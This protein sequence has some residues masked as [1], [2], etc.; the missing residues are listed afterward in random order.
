[1]LD[2]LKISPRAKHKGN[3]SHKAELKAD[4][5]YLFNLTGQRYQSDRSQELTENLSNRDNV[6]KNV[7]NL[8]INM[9]IFIL[10]F[11]C[12]FHTFSRPINDEK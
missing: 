3:K 5:P 9:C 1:M 4:N 8:H 12:T 11:F 10:I 2:S 7:T 6:A